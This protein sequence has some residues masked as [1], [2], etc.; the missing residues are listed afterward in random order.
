MDN[1]NEDAAQAQLD[2]MEPMVLVQTVGVRKLKKVKVYPLSVK[3]QLECTRLLGS[4]A[5]QL[6][7][8]DATT[9]ELVAKFIY[10][11]ENDIDFILKKI[12]E[13]EVNLDNITNTQLTELLQ[14]IYLM[15]YETAS[16]N[17]TDLSGKV[18][19]LFRSERS[20]PK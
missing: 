2:S 10:F 3:D 11:I 9:Q 14:L 18:K 4:V 1:M 8:P 19:D 7:K 17:L 6:Q 16:K 15:N 13:P 20:L 5:D 12:T